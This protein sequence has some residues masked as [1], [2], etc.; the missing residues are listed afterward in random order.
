MDRASAYAP[1]RVELL[2]N[3]TDY[4]QGF[5]LA[6]AIDRGTTV[7]GRKRRDGVILVV[8]KTL[9]RRFSVPLAD[10]RPHPSEAWANYPLGVTREL[11]AAGFEVRGYE[12]EIETDLPIGSGLSSSAALE[13]ATAYFLG[14]TYGLQIDPRQIATLCRKAEN[15]FVGV[16][17]G[18]LDQMTCLFGRNG[19]VV[20]LDCRSEQVATVAMP[21]DVALVVSDSGMSR[22]LLQ[23]EYNQRRAECAAAAATLGVNSLREVS[24]QQLESSPIDPLLYRRAAHIVGENE[25]VARAVQALTQGDASGFGQQMYESHESSRRY[26][27]N[28]T[29]E[30]DLL[31]SIART[32]PGVFGA[33]LTG[34]GFG[35]STIALVERERAESIGREIEQKYVA[36]TGRDVRAFICRV[37]DG[38]A[39]VNG[40][41]EGGAPI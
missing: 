40:P 34:G 20:C 25:R 41:A 27:E 2:G 9:G 28:S 7:S 31:V 30:L 38:A 10:L 13:I 11:R 6:A 36:A 17:C 23:S 37:A 29:P 19:H 35:G 33:R 16:S 1:G 3:H 14:K 32:L 4:N 21:P 26:F 5:V 15:E 39:I 22:S 12:A 8:S 24:R 18:L